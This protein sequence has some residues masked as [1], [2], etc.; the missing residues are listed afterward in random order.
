MIDIAAIEQH[1]SQQGRFCL[2]DWLLADNVLFYA[3]YESWRYGQRDNLDD[4]LQLDNDA[5]LGLIVEA[6]KHCNSLGLVAEVQ[7]YHRWD[8][9]RD[10]VLSIS[11]DEYKNQQL[12]QLWM[13]PQDQPQLD[14]F[15]DNSAQMAENA[16]LDALA[17][18]QFQPA[19]TQLESLSELNAECSR[20]GGYQDLI[21]YGLHMVDNPIIDPDALDAERQGLIEEVS[22]LALDVLGRLARDYLSFA[23]RRLADGLMPLAFDPTRP[24]YHASSALLEI[25]DY[26]AVVACLKNDD[27]LFQQPLLLERLALGLNALHKDENALVIWCLMMEVDASYTETALDRLRA[28]KVN[29]FWQDFWELNDDWP[30][31]L[32]P[33][34]LLA[35]R[36]SLLHYLDD[37]PDLRSPASEAMVSLLKLRQK[38]E[39]E[40]PAR[41]VLKGISP[42]LLSVY[43]G[44]R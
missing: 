15:M 9:D 35:R 23:W 42:E 7:A 17:G 1:L 40:I 2:V 34:Y 4:V 37:L 29:T 10:T 22:P 3:D 8:S 30:C 38:Q 33:A 18:R 16:L 19:Q 31:E 44:C 20:L 11:E 13:R 26:A 12:S 28:H 5:L 6:N 41:S 25:P 32:F 36:P 43:L 27:N 24:G 14:L 39:D 21:N